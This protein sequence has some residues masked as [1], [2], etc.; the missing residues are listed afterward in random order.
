MMV[1][2]WLTRKCN[3]QCTYCYEGEKQQNPMQQKTFEDTLQF[4]ADFFKSSQ[5][6]YLGITFHGGEPMLEYKKIIQ[7]IDFFSGQAEMMNK[8]SYMLTTN[9]TLMSNEQAEFLAKNISVSISIDGNKTQHDT[10][11]VFPDGRGTYEL[12]VKNCKKILKVNNKVRARMTVTK[13]KIHY[14]YEDFIAIFKIGFKYIDI[15][16]DLYADE[17]STD[18][19]NEYLEQFRRIKKFV[20][21]NEEKISVGI[22]RGKFNKKGLCGG[23]KSSI[24][25]DYNGDIYPCMLSVAHLEFKIGDIYKGIDPLL[26]DW[27]RDIGLKDNQECQGCKMASYCEGNRCKIVNY[28]IN[29]DYYKPANSM[30][31]TTNLKVDLQSI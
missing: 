5:E 25:I 28:I 4:I 2:L 26:V 27:I 23:G 20:S 19:Y 17:W 13:E 7:C 21:E 14:L 9:G 1:T 10:C 11:R 8:V 22:L 31:M 3:L 12:V 18:E 30:C 29:K 6:E 24:S 16:L 15:I